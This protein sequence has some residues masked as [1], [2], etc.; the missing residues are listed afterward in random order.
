M[1][2]AEQRYRAVVESA[3]CGILVVDADG[4]VRDG[5]AQAARMLGITAEKLARESL[6]ELCKHAQHEEGSTFDEHAIRALI[7][8]DAGQ[9]RRRSVVQFRRDDGSLRR[10]ALSPYPIGPGDAADSSGAVIFLQEE[11]I[12]T[13]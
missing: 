3:P 1:R 5:N 13:F 4:N 12:N 9:Q 2:Q 10:I 11:M 8:P 7:R 6:M